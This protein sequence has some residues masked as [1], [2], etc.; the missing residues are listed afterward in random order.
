MPG[1]PAHDEQEQ[2]GG[3]VNVST[4]DHTDTQGYAP[5]FWRLDPRGGPPNSW[6]EIWIT[7]SSSH[8]VAPH[9]ALSGLVGRC[10]ASDALPPRASDGCSASCCIVAG[11]IATMHGADLGVSFVVAGLVTAAGAVALVQPS[12]ARQHPGSRC[13]GLGRLC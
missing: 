4:A 2:G 1:V 10:R 12:G 13:L 3:A 9:S 11:A 8:L 6:C 7:E 5:L